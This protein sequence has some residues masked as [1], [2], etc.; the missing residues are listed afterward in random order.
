VGGPTALA[1]RR[2]VNNARSIDGLPALD[3]A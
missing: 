1:Q 3:E 2:A